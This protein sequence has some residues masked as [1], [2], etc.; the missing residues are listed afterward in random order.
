M[1]TSPTALKQVQPTWLPLPLVNPQAYTPVEH[2][3]PGASIPPDA[4]RERIGRYD[5]LQTLFDGDHSLITSDSEMHFD[6]LQSNYFRLIPKSFA[7]MMMGFPPTDP[8]RDDEL[9]HQLADAVY[10][11]LIDYA[12]FGVG[13][14]YPWTDDDGLPRITPISP[15]FWYPMPDEAGDVWIAP[16]SKHVDVYILEVDGVREMR[17]YEREERELEGEHA[18]VLGRLIER[19]PIANVSP[20][21][22]DQAGV[23]PPDDMGV[24]SG[25]SSNS[26]SMDDAPKV[27]GVDDS[28]PASQSGEESYQP[29]EPS[30]RAI[31]AVQSPPKLGEFGYSWLPELAPFNVALTQVQTDIRNV[32]HRHSYPLLVEVGQEDVMFSGDDADTFAAL[33]LAATAKRGGVYATPAANVE[34]LT[35]DSNLEALF[36]QR[37]DLVETMLT[38]TGLPISIFGIFNENSPTGAVSGEALRRTYVVA[39]NMIRRVQREWLHAINQLLALFGPGG[40]VE[41]P[42][43]LGEAE[44]GNSEPMEDN[45]DVFDSADSADAGDDE[46]SAA[47]GADNR[48]VRARPVRRANAPPPRR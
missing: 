42:H 25:G 39:Y 37:D 16:A 15:R 2:W 5:L 27:R 21:P 4:A 36:K 46:E 9:M 45:E 41:W 6:A 8:A 29:V 23:E 43:P 19:M 30:K 22:L 18:S 35:W 31:L 44:Q 7:D 10:Q 17:R 34:Y 13:L 24:A 47:G 32:A 20:A 12:V 14:L 11:S 3:Q 38:M 1:T 40:E 33:E 28:S 48:Q 26:D